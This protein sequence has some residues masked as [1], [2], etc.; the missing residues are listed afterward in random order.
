MNIWK[1]GPGI[2]HYSSDGMVSFIFHYSRNY[3]LSR[4]IAN[5]VCY[6]FTLLYAFVPLPF[7]NDLSIPLFSIALLFPVVFSPSFL[8]LHYY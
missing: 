4:A 8:H 2:F 7:S 3:S 6:P 5:A 1:L